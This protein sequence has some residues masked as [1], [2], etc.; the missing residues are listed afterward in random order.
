MTTLLSLKSTAE[1]GRT[2]PLYSDECILILRNALKNAVEPPFATVKTMNG[3]SRFDIDDV[4]LASSS[5]GG[6]HSDSLSDDASSSSEPGGVV[7]PVE[8]HKSTGAP[9]NAVADKANR[10]KIKAPKLRMD[11]RQRENVIRRHVQALVTVPV[12]VNDDIARTRQLNLC[13]PLALLSRH[14]RHQAVAQRL[15]LGARAVSLPILQSF[16][17]LALAL[18]G[19]GGT[20]LVVI[21]HVRSGRFAAV[22]YNTV[23]QAVVDHRTATRYTIRKKQGKSQSANDGQHGKAQSKGAQLRRAGIVALQ[24]DMATVLQEWKDAGYWSA[25][26]T[27]LILVSCPKTM[28][29]DLYGNGAILDR[30]DPR[31]RKIPMA[32]DRPSYETC[33]I[34]YNTL[35]HNM[36]IRDADLEPLV[37]TDNVEPKR[38]P[39]LPPVT[40][41]LNAQQLAALVLKDVGVLVHSGDLVAPKVH[42]LLP[43]HEAARDGNAALL[44]SLI[45]INADSPATGINQV[46]GPD[47][48]TPLHYAAAAGSLPSSAS[49]GSN[50]GE[51]GNADDQAESMINKYTAAAECVSLLLTLGKADPCAIDGRC[52]VPYFLANHDRVRDAFRMARAVLGEEYC[53]WDA[54]AKVG[55]PLTEHDVEERKRREQEKKRKK[56]A[57]QK[58][59]IQEE[60]AQEAAIAAEKQKEEADLKAAE[61]AKRTRDGL[62]PKTNPHSCDFCQKPLKSG[63][64][65]EVF[66]RL[67]YKYCSADCVQKH[68]R[69]LMAGAALRRFGE[70]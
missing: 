27:K 25:E 44:R 58:A 23:N 70:S 7:P 56:K 64:R 46:A 21:L 42:A 15:S 53:D 17:S 59:K 55:P 36:V 40:D 4:S 1:L 51:D 6:S 43:I 69:E 49:I 61:E 26:R 66:T 33:T 29:Q 60:K 57:R 5:D 67:E 48:M 20:P 22:V 47:G 54:G 12:P 68:K 3:Q 32:L 10:P 31:I 50:G 28:Q 62:T 2:V 65:S 37:N 16:L 30:Q 13:L 38:K 14:D 9:Q 45:S 19:S 8:K 52:R 11:P 41:E 24:Q 34:V 18:R 39:T 63:R 35:I